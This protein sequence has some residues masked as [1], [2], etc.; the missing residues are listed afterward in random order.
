MRIIAGKYRR[1]KLLANPGLTTRPITDRTREILFEH[2]YGGLEDKRVADVFAGTG[3]IGLESLSRGA[4][5]VVFI[6]NDRRAH[7]LLKQ[8]VE[9]LEVE[10]QTLCWRADVLRTSFRPKG[11]DALLPF[12][13]VFFDPPY[14]MVPGLKIG[15]ILYKS[16]ERLARDNITAPDAWLI[17]R[18]PK[19]AE[20]EIPPVWQFDWTLEAGTMTIHKFSKRNDAA[21]DAR[22][23]DAADG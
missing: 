9:T 11:V 23:A 20:F 5:S 8:N 12:D 15:S 13:V 19:H 22:P 16:L 21:G 1:R 6:E 17:F 18:T 3:T 2:L 10:E 14:A 4:A 7:R